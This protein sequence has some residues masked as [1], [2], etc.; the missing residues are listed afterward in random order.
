MLDAVYVDTLEEK[1]IVAIRP[2]AALRPLLEIA[3]TREDSGVVLINETPP[4][5]DDSEASSCSWWRRGR[6]EFY[7]K[8]GL[9]VLVA[10]GWAGIARK[11]LGKNSNAA[12]APVL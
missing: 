5:P 1:A 11:V 8:H 4:D 9:A 10:A 7:L 6:V 2:K 12:L 3:T